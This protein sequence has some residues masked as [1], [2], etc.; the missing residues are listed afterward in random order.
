[1]KIITV[2]TESKGY[3]PYLQ[4]SAK[5]HHAELVTLGWN[6]A[7]KGFTWRLHLMKD[8]LATLPR[9]E[10]ICFVDG[11]DVLLLRN[12]D[13]LETAFKYFAGTHGVQMVVGCEN[14]PLLQRTLGTYI[15]K[16]CNDRL[17]NAGT[18]IGYA[19]H[20]LR[21]LTDIIKQSRTHGDDDQVILTQY[22]RANPQSIYIDC[23]GHFFLTI[24]RPFGSFLTDTVYVNKNKEVVHNGVKPFIAHG[25]GSTDMND[26]IKLLGYTMTREQEDTMRQFLKRER[27][28][29]TLYYSKFFVSLTIVICVCTVLYKIVKHRMNR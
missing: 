5:K 15:F 28:K 22:C 4:A 16:K 8:F 11:Y 6:Q 9:D 23:D 20:I 24:S 2:A 18:Y 25:N 19:G 1:M 29:K 12:V 26:L 27:I 17:L 21:M 10:V 13:E 14:S 3:Y 7:W